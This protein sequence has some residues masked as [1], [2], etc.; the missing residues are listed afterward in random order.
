MKYRAFRLGRALTTVC[1]AL[2][3]LT[4]A[5][6]HDTASAA[7]RTLQ[8]SS[9]PVSGVGITASFNGAPPV[10]VTTANSRLIAQ[11]ATVSLTAPARF[12]YRPF[13]EWWKDG[14]NP[15]SQERTIEFTVDANVNMIATYGDPTYKLSVTSSPDVGIEFLNEDITPLV[16]PYEREFPTPGEPSEAIVNAPLVYNG[17]TFSRWLVNGVETST[18]HVIYLTMDTDYTIEAQYGAGSI[19]STIQPK[20]VRRKARWRVDGGEWLRRG[21]TVGDLRV[22]DH[23]VEW[24]PVT[25]YKTPKP[26]VVPI[27]DGDAHTIRG[28]YFPL[29]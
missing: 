20:D 18:L 6:G 24:K 28:R 5:T 11:G 23:L 16:T 1:A 14:F 12:Q 29:K 7:N 22:G 3:A 9:F 21:V 17:K 26:R 2:L 27:E 4:W 25:G 19:M 15:Y 10:V 8:I 13:V